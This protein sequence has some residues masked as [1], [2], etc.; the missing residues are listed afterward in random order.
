MRILHLTIK[1]KFFDMIASGEKLEEYRTIKPYWIRRLFTNKD[2]IEN[3]V[4]N[5]FCNDLL[6]PLVNHNSLNELL[7]YFGFEFVKFDAAEFKNGYS[8]TSS[9]M[10]VEFKGIEIGKA[11]P[12]WSDNWQ[13]DV[14]KIKLGKIIKQ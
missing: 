2:Y 10:I 4:W 11:K 3:D 6:N 5:E 13:G 14:F 12:E 8:K 7:D 1:K 9:T